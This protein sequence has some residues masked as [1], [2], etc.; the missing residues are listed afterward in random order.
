M[1]A[2]VAVINIHRWLRKPKFESTLTDTHQHS[3]TPF[4]PTHEVTFSTTHHHPPEPKLEVT[5]INIHRRHRKPE[6]VSTLTDT[7]Q[8]QTLN[9]SL[10]HSSPPP[11]PKFESHSPTLTDTHQLTKL[12]NTL[13]PQT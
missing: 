5:V 6:F 12:T 4:K 3:P 13:Q 1:F 10:E 8:T 2:E 7:L 9:D 11:K